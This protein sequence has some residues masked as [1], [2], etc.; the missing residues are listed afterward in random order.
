MTP[1]SMIAQFLFTLG[2]TLCGLFFV[3]LA[4]AGCSRPAE[5]L[6]IGVNPWPGFELLHIA[7]EQGYFR[8]EGV[9]VRLVEFDSLGDSR[10]AFER[11]QTDVFGATPTE[12]RLSREHSSRQAQ[13]F[14]IVDFS[15]GADV[16]LARPGIGSVRELCGRRIGAE[17]AAMDVVLL[18]FALQS[19]GMTLADV[20]VVPL[21][22]NNMAAALA[23]KTVDA[24]C[25]Y[26]PYADDILR[27]GLARPV[28]DSS[29]IPGMI[30]DVLAGDAEMIARRPQDL[31]AVVRALERARRY[32]EEHPEQAHPTMARRERMSVP[33]LRSA[34]AA[35]KLV[36]LHEQPALFGANGALE[37]SLNMTEAALR[38][39][40][41]VGITLPALAGQRDDI[42]RAAAR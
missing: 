22:Q 6:R 32:L 16:V 29:D 39:M 15:V 2:R 41:M 35:L 9:E 8:A 3:V 21:T 19:A 12:L 5:P 25:S 28:F 14:Y 18:S 24:V 38:R 17:P 42:V 23:D 1:V 11:G 7:E 33:E 37:K 10:R 20:T 40:D 26:P 31:A 34:L 30:V 36:P 27:R 4:M 13:A